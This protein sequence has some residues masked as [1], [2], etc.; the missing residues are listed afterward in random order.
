MQDLL[1]SHCYHEYDWCW[2]CV[3]NK[4][5]KITISTAETRINQGKL[6]SHKLSEIWSKIEVLLGSEIGILK[7]SLE[8]LYHIVM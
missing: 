1:A 7:F 8:L 5:T 6:A 2:V 4:Q 3:P